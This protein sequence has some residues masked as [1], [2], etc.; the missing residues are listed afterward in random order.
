MGQAQQERRAVLIVEDDADLR[1]PN[2]AIACAC[3]VNADRD[4]HQAIRSALQ[5]RRGAAASAARSRFAGRLQITS[6]I[7]PP[8][9]ASTI[10]LLKG[11]LGRPACPSAQARSVEQALRQHLCARDWHMHGTREH[12]VVARTATR[13]ETARHSSGY[14][15]IARP[16]SPSCRPSTEVSA[17]DQP[18]S[19]ANCVLLHARDFRIIW[20][21]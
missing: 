7:P 5:D 8:M 14:E 1:S 4:Q 13:P 18:S 21:M 11:G 20:R 9:S 10:A 19:R 12:A 17:H 3:H 2:G 16:Y 15:T 6:A